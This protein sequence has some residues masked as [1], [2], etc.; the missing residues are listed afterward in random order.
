MANCE[1]T[2][3]KL[4]VGAVVIRFIREIPDT[5]LVQ[6]EINNLEQFGFTLV[7]KADSVEVYAEVADTS[8]YSR[9]TRYDEKAA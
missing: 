9:N 5:M 6:K 3:R 7:W 1:A 4:Y 2:G 8:L